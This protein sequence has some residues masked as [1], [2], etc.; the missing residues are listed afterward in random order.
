MGESSRFRR[1]LLDAVASMRVGWPS[2]PRTQIGP[3]IEPPREKL[4][5]GLTTLGEG[6]RWLLAPQAL[7]ASGQLYSPGVRSEEHTSELQSRGHL[8]CRLLLEKKKY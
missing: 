7:D 5:A 8:V 4:H 1:Q 6:E 3:V 2:D